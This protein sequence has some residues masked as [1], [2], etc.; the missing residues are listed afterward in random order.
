MV[1]Q[2]ARYKLLIAGSKHDIFDAPATR[3]SVMETDIFFWNIDVIVKL[4]RTRISITNYITSFQK[5]NFLVFAVGWLGVRPQL[6]FYNF[7]LFW[8][9][10][11]RSYDKYD[12][13]RCSV[14]FDLI[15]IGANAIVNE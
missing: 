5:R 4:S 12:T 11:L 8:N 15:L 6:I 9:L 7:V 1:I 13:T 14:S 3:K 10:S 2:D